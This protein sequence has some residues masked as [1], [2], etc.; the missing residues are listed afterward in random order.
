MP[1]PFQQQAFGADQYGQFASGDRS[2]QTAQF[3]QSAIT[4]NDFGLNDP[5]AELQARRAQNIPQVAQPN[6]FPATPD[7]GTTPDMRKPGAVKQI[8]GGFLYGMSQALKK[9]AG[10]ATDYDIANQMMQN[11]R[12]D[13]EQQRAMTEEG[14]RGALQQYNQ[15]RALQLE[16]QPLTQ[17][18]SDT[19]KGM[20]INIAPG[21]PIHPNAYEGILKQG[22]VNKGKTDVQSIKSG[23][24]VPVPQ[25][26]AK[27]FGLPLDSLVSLD[28]FN[29]MASASGKNLIKTDKMIDGKPHTAI[30]DKTTGEVVHDLG[31]S[32]A[33]RQSLDRAWA[34]ATARKENTVTDVYDDQGNLRPMTEGQRLRAGIPK[35][36]TEFAQQG[37][38]S[39]TRTAGQAAGAVASHI[40]AYLQSVD[41]L[42]AKGE[43]GA[44]MGRL[45]EYMN[46]GYFGDDPDVARFVADTKLLKSGT[47][48]AHFGARGGAQILDSFDRMLNTSQ[49]P[50]AIKGA[51]A[52]IN[53]W[54][55]TY[56]DIGQF[57]PQRNQTFKPKTFVPDKP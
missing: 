37:P 51:V 50:N 40:P 13:I 22:V 27:Q 7:A 21:T 10:L 44:V 1:F 48:R 2:P 14:Y 49:E 43:L 30:V 26:M 24:Q 29:K 52:S 12:I 55:K 18:Q 8:L 17:Q 28:T 57:K 15:Q 45:N 11:R 25:A 4:G 39:Q 53:D 9:D 42:A 35:A 36:Q 33:Y 23:P 31:D 46:S 5:F 3:Q 20:G 6:D 34:F 19:L 54:L 41:N 47:V 16:T 56:G 38:T 32:V